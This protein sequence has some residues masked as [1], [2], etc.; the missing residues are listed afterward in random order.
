MH[1]ECGTLVELEPSTRRAVGKMKATITQRFK[2]G[3][4]EYDV[5]CDCRFI[6]FCEKVA[7]STDPSSWQATGQGERHWSW[8]VK[9]VKLIYEK[10]KVVPVNGALPKFEED[11][12][13]GLP[14]GYRYLGAAQRRLGYGIDK[15]LVTLRN[16][17]GMGRMYG[18]VERW[19]EGGDAELFW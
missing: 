9:Y 2:E 15:G 13:D 6:F 14:E 11:E 8:H 17:E 5:D 3:G 19:L 4:T 12:L 18:S 1:R 10:D 7:A 16:K